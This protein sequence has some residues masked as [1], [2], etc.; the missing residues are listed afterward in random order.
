[1]LILQPWNSTTAINKGLLD[2]RQFGTHTG[3][4]GS[5][6]ACNLPTNHQ[7]LSTWR[8]QGHFN[9]QPAQT[10][11]Y[12]HFPTACIHEGEV[13]SEDQKKRVKRANI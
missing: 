2:I 9:S 5:S 11:N 13:R 7:N 4:L 6:L 1:M 3:G 12:S 8:F 10:L